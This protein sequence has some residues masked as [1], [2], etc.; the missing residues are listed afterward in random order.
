MQLDEYWWYDIIISQ[1]YTRSYKYMKML[2]QQ[3]TI[4]VHLQPAVCAAGQ[5]RDG[6]GSIEGRE[7]LKLLE[8]VD[9]KK[10]R[11]FREKVFLASG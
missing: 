1:S 10:S 11:S 8:V 7:L 3:G 6:S 5:D 9:L 2:I 4:T